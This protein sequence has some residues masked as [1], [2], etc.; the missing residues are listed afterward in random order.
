MID[1]MVRP[2]L[3]QDME[4]FRLQGAQAI[5]HAPLSKDE[6]VALEDE[7]SF[8]VLCDG[9]IAAVFGLLIPWRGRGQGWAYISEKMPRKAWPEITRR[10]IMSMTALMNGMDLHRLEV[11]VATA[12]E[13]GQRWAERLGFT[14]EAKLCKYG[15]DGSD[16]FLYAIT[17]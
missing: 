5:S 6:A 8:T 11:T 7:I 13:A 1:I 9:E 15:P 17:A 3:A 16:F 2:F 12:H 4:G 14:Q 10:A